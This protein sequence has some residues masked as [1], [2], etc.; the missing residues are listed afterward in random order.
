MILSI[1]DSF[2]QLH[3]Q[4]IM[5]RLA[6]EFVTRYGHLR[7]PAVVVLTDPKHIKVWDEYLTANGEKVPAS[8]KQRKIKTYSLFKL[9]DIPLKGDFDLENVRDS[10]YF[11]H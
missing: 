7:I 6:S 1:F 8:S 10:I 4:D 9:K 2:V 5:K 11:F 3:Q